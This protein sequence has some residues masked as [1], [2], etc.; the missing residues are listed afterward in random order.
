MRLVF[1]LAFFDRCGLPTASYTIQLRVLQ[2]GH[3]PQGSA[4]L[5]MKAYSSASHSTVIVAISLESVV[6]T[7]QER[8]SFSSRHF[9]L[10]F[11]STVLSPPHLLP[12]QA[13]STDVT[14][15]PDLLGPLNQFR[16]GLIV[17]SETLPRVW[18]RRSALGTP[19]PLDTE[20]STWTS[21]RNLQLTKPPC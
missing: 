6:N 4:G 17:D 8:G 2:L 15:L 10:S 18:V 19:S 16:L 20:H 11:A 7:K 9:I 14:V 5:R 21:W 12:A 1:T 13:C 3:Y